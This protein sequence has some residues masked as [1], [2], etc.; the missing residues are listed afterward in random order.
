MYQVM[1]NL[2]LNCIKK[3]GGGVWGSSPRIFF[4]ELGTKLGNSRHF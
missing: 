1:F 3:G 4:T 2:Y